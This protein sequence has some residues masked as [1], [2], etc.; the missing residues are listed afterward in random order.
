MGC[1]YCEEPRKSTREH[2][3]PNFLL[4]SESR[5]GVFYSNAAQRYFETDAVVKD[6]CAI[7][8]N[9]ILGALDVY[10]SGL[11]NKYFARTLVT[12][13]TVAF[14]FDRLLRWV[15][16]V[17]FNAQRA[18]G[19]TPRNLLHLRA[20]ML[21]RSA[22]S[23]SLMFFGAVM[24]RSWMDGEWKNP[25]DYRASDIR[26]PE[27]DLHL[28]IKFCHM[29]VINSFCFIV[30]DLITEGSGAR[31]RL[32]SFLQ[33]EIGAREIVPDSSSFVFDSEVSKIDHVG[34]NIRQAAQNPNVFP[35]N[36]EVL[37]GNKRMVHTGIP[38][39]YVIRRS[40]FRDG[41]NQMMTIQDESGRTYACLVTAGSTELRELELGFRA[42]E[43]PTSKRCYAGVVRGE[44]KTYIT[45]YDPNE[46]G[47][48][49]LSMPTGTEQSVENWELF[50]NAI[51]GNNN[52]LF[53]T[54]KT[55][56]QDFQKVY[57]AIEVIS[58]QE[59]PRPC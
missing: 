47:A 37:V 31:E 32:A 49:F 30:A 40:R 59:S 58:I 33:Y 21:G 42:E 45:I 7:C 5:A 51:L 27:M 48:P 57:N 38:K 13:R 56:S 1:I 3:F 29:L 15:L 25:R 24:R 36:K 35:D 28:E 34:H 16:K 10:A 55:F 14:D 26:I 18:F 20:Y 54:D 50:K 44:R 53:L 46:P 9:E 6:T 23:H 8:N 22:R 43:I 39:D 4:K 11:Y 41:K 17:S 52:R 12:S 2:V 19:G